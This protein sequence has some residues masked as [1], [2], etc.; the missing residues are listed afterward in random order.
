MTTATE[1][2]P[3]LAFLDGLRLN[4]S[5]AW[6]DEHRADYEA[7]R[8]AFARFVSDLIDERRAPDQL[9]GLTA[10]QCIFRLN[11]DI[12][13][14][15]D[16]SPYN[17]TVSALI[18]P[19]G[20]KSTTQ[21]YYIAIGPRGQSMVAGGLYSPTSAQLGRF[22]EAIAADATPFKQV[23]SAAAF[24]ATFGEVEGSRLKTAPRGYNRDHPEIA[25]LRLKQVIAARRFSDQDV[26]AA[27]FGV[28]VRSAMAAIRPFL[29]Y[30][31]GIQQ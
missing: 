6:V 3:I 23:T 29:R 5:K 14:S 26:L 2:Q 11:R 28:Q 24:V 17:T 7:A 20:R 1:F 4:N 8:D 12:R 30:L 10:K 9:H 16:K 15:K 27:D 25:L 19:G 22:R 13:F 31:D 18:A 21:G